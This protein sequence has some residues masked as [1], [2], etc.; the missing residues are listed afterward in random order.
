MMNGFSEGYMGIQQTTSG[1][2]KVLF[3]V[4]SPYTTDDP[5]DIPEEKRVKVLRKGANVT[6]GE[7]GNE[8]SGGQK[9]GCIITG[10]PVRC[11]KLLYG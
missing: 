4:W 7:F 9:A 10:Q 5:E 3:S 2:H 6:I 8:G 11:T 1:E